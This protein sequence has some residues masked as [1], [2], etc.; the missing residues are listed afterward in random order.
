MSILGRHATARFVER[1]AVVFVGLHAFAAVAVGAAL[2]AGAPHLAWEHVAR[3]VPDALLGLL[4][5]TLPVCVWAAAVWVTVEAARDG[6]H[7]DLTLAGRSRAVVQVPLLVVALGMGGVLWWA[8]TRVLPRAAVSLESEVAAL[9]ADPLALAA[10]LRDDPTRLG[11]LDVEFDGADRD[12]LR[13]VR[14]AAMGGSGGVALVADR[15]GLD[16]ATTGGL[17]LDRGRL[18]VLTDAG[19]ARHDLLFDRLRLDPGSAAERG[20]DLRRVPDLRYFTDGDLER[21]PAHRRHL[22]R[23]GVHLGRPARRRVVRAG[24]VRLARVQGVLLVPL[25]VLVPWLC[26]GRGDERLVRRLGVSG[27]LFLGV[28]LPLQL[29]LLSQARDGALPVDLLTLAPTGLVVLG[30][31]ARSGLAAW[32]AR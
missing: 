31:C 27:L 6:L 25:A 17:T 16:A 7:Q 30:V 8:S 5:V 9:A 3:L 10:Q 14:A 18:L 32:S 23:R 19:A 29:G 15:V 2:P 12:G 20:P 13:G 1:L 26:L 11:G 21:L 24:Q 22:R 28:L 4:P